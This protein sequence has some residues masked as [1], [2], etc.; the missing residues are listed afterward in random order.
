[1]RVGH[2]RRDKLEQLRELLERRRISP[3]G[4]V[5][6]TRHR[7]EVTS[8]EYEYM[9]EPGGPVPLAPRE[10]AAGLAARISRSLDR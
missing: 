10:A 9:S 3:L 7:P 4:F 8:S 1:V 6:T 2:T 5:V